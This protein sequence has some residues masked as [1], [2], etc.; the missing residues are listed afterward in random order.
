MICFNIF[1]ASP[2]CLYP[3]CLIFFFRSSPVAKLFLLAT[4]KFATRDAYG[5][6]IEYE[7]DKPGWN[8]AMNGLPGMIGSGM[9]ETFELLVLMRYLLST[10]SKYKRPVIVP[11]ELINLIDGITLALDKL[12]TSGYSDSPNLSVDV[13]VELF[14]YWDDVASA[15]EE[16]RTATKFS[17]SG[18]EHTLPSSEAISLLNQWIIQLELGISRSLSIGHHGHG[19]NGTSGLTPTYFSFIVSKWEKTGKTNKDGHFLVVPK[20]MEVGRFP[21]FL[22]GPVHM[23]KTVGTTGALSIYSK[24]KNSSLHDDG[25]NMYTISGSLEGQSYDMGRM[26]AFSPGWLENQSV[27]L[28]MSYKYYLQLIRNGLHK[29]FFDEMVSGGMLPFMNPDIYGRSLMQCSS[30]IA[31][32]AFMDPSVR[33]RGFLPR[34]SGATAEFLSMWVLMFIGPQP[35]FVDDNSNE[36]H[37]QL[38]PTLPTWLF[39]NDG[40]DL[41]V[42]FELF[43]AINVTYH[44]E[45]QRDIVGISPERYVVGLRDGSVMKVDGPTIPSDL[46]I[47]IRR[48]VFVE[49]I[50]AYF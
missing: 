38:Q 22:E 40:I 21:L 13:P 7:A 27:W 45:K 5:M 8:D 19:D 44:N 23:M 3:Y 2:S 48:V 36:L 50:D 20:Q 4:I 1:F 32:S 26:M 15:R 10:V 29:Q 11:T 35:F 9:P 17:F 31:S 16:Y 28:H 43:S 42:S 39:K 33:G 41:Q 14:K 30:F 47:K 24:V 6:G 34:L 12:E 25:L 46:A 49:Y 37:M 18:D